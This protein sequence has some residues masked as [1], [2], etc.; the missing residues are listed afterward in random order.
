VLTCSAVAGIVDYPGLEWALT[1]RR[2][3]TMQLKSVIFSQVCLTPKGENVYGEVERGWMRL[4]ASLVSLAVREEPNAAP[5]EGLYFPDFPKI[6]EECQSLAFVYLDYPNEDLDGNF[7]MFLLVGM[8]MPRLEDPEIGC[9]AI[10][11]EQERRMFTGIVVH[12]SGAPLVPLPME[13]EALCEK[14]STNRLYRARS[15]SRLRGRL[16]PAGQAT[17][18]ALY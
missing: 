3:V 14:L 9:Y 18:I 13:R 8:S 1:L 7:A 16:P 10:H 4:T 11:S 12:P 17:E 6:S 5:S 2:R 15:T